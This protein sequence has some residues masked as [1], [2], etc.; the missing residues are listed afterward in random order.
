MR[1]IIGMLLLAASS[2]ALADDLQ[3]VWLEASSKVSV[4]SGKALTCDVGISTDAIG[5]CRGFADYMR[6]NW[7]KISDLS[8]KIGAY[9]AQQIEAKVPRVDFERYSDQMKT[10]ARV[11]AEYKEASQSEAAVS[12]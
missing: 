1:S 10:I 5:D 4:A 7:R 12:K 8:D 6:K 2:T 9:T 3:T 11:S